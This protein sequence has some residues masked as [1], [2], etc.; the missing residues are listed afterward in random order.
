MLS[1]GFIGPNG[2]AVGACWFKYRSRFEGY[3]LQEEIDGGQGRTAR[4]GY[5]QLLVV[6]GE[7]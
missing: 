2:H 7:T 1:L 6:K 5:S 4:P 3:S